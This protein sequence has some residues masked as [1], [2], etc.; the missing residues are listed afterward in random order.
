[1]SQ[2]TKTKSIQSISSHKDK[3]K[4]RKHNL[5]NIENLQKSLL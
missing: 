2:L 5:K 4:Q 3:I 1:M